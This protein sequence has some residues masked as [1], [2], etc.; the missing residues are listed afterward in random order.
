MEQVLKNI[1]GKDL[2]NKVKLTLEDNPALKEALIV[3]G[4][5]YLLSKDDK[6]RN[7]IVTAV[8]TFIL[9]DGHL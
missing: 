5:A 3:G 2:F 6:L 4:V 7:A 8:S 1:I 9:K